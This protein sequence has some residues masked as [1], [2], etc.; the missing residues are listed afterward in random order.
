MLP[1]SAPYSQWSPNRGESFTRTWHV[2]KRDT[3]KFK[4]SLGFG[5]KY[6]Y[7]GIWQPDESDISTGR[8]MPHNTGKNC[9]LLSKIYK[10]HFLYIILLMKIKRNIVI[11]VTHFLVKGFL[12]SLQWSQYSFFDDY[13]Q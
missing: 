8:D 5:Q 6:L 9:H 4:F 10:Y 1:L 12:W 13:L 7:E 2:K 11:L 3:E